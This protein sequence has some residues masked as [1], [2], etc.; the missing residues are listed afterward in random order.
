MA[1][2][3]VYTVTPTTNLSPNLQYINTSQLRQKSA[4]ASDPGPVYTGVYDRKTVRADKGDASKER[5]REEE[6]LDKSKEALKQ[7]LDR[8]LIKR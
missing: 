6:K 2:E 1:A 7:L 8:R 3:N 5:V 4:K